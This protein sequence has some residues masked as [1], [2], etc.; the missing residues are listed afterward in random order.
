MVSGAI[1]I[2]LHTWECIFTS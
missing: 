1:C 2:S